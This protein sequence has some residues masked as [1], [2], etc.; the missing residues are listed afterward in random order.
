MWWI[1]Q[2]LP[3]LLTATD[4]QAEDIKD[5]EAKLFDSETT[6]KSYDGRSQKIRK[7]T[8][9]LSTE[10]RIPLPSN[11]P[12]DLRTNERKI[13]QTFTPTETTCPYRPGPTPPELGPHTIITT[14]ATVYGVTKTHKDGNWKLAFYV[15]VGTVRRPDLEKPAKKELEEALGVSS[16]G[17][18]A[19]IK[20]QKT[21]VYYIN[22]LFWRESARDYVDG[23]LSFKVFPTVFVSDIAG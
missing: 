7:M 18:K 15:P 21:G 11:L 8:E 22:F 16:E 6:R 1:F 19:F 23:L 12:L 4:V 5:L 20:L 3:Q 2:E 13:P 10:K 17:P 14:Q 9:Y